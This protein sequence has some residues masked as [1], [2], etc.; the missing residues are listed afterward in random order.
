MFNKQYLST[1]FN[2]NIS[3]IALSAQ[4]KDRTLL[5]V[6]DQRIVNKSSGLQV[7]R[8]RVYQRFGN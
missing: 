8:A 5:F 6:K 1:W 2:S 7:G 3:W 4:V